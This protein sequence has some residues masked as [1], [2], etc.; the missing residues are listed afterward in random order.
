V[1]RLKDL[2][3]NNKNKIKADNQKEDEK[4]SRSRSENSRD[5]ENSVFSFQ[6]KTPFWIF[7]IFPQI[8]SLKISFE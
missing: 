1:S 8:F 5:K 3:D 2:N 7:L 4:D 6:G